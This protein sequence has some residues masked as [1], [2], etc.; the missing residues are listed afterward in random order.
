MNRW[1]GRIAMLGGKATLAR[2]LLTLRLVLH[3]SDFLFEGIV[4]AMS[5]LFPVS[6]IV[7]GTD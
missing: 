5:R 1:S 2:E 3:T 4:A 6:R 7:K